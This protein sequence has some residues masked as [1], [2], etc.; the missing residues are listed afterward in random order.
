MPENSQICFPKV[1]TKHSDT[2]TAA[3]KRYADQVEEEELSHTN[4]SDVG[5][6]LQ[7]SPMLSE[8]LAGDFSRDMLTVSD[9]IVTDQ[10]Q[11]KSQEAAVVPKA[12]MIQGRDLQPSWSRKAMPRSEIHVSVTQEVVI[13]VDKSELHCP[14]VPGT[15]QDLQTPRPSPTP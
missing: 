5:H 4:D 14:E 6:M 11:V 15:V 8:G 9:E 3:P 7:S 13:E 1:P 2:V 12:S 10:E